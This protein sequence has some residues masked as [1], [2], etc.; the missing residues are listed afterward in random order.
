M[1]K[2]TL[3]LL[4][5]V[6]GGA[7]T[8]AVG[9]PATATDSNTVPV[10]AHCSTG[11]Y[12]NNDGDE[13][14]RKPTVVPGGLEFSGNQLV[15]HAPEQTITLNNLHH[16]TYSASPAPSLTSFFSVEVYD[17]TTKGYATLRWDTHDNEWVLGGNPGV[18][19]PTAEDFVGTI[20]KW[21]ILTQQTQVISFGVGYVANPAN[22][23]TTV[24]SSVSFV[25]KTYLLTNCAPPVHH[26]KPSCSP[27][28][29]PSAS[30]SASASATPSESTSASA[31]ASGSASASASQSTSL[32]LTGNSGSGGSLPVTGFPLASLV[33]GAVL[34]V[35]AGTTL[36]ILAR[37]R[38]QHVE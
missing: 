5:L 12:V 21:G 34:V 25:D 38:K 4:A 9:T 13:N 16:G 14:T 27:S 23:T 26:P 19:H 3:A 30:G 17:S 35:G 31:S 29:S 11:W 10:N 8:L 1:S 33:G 36:V 32:V 20:T 28:V 22:G 37:R 15:H 7:A 24:V 2:R 18:E 6:A